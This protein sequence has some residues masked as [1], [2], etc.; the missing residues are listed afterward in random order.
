MKKLIAGGAAILLALGVAGASV[1]PAS[2]HYYHHYYGYGPGA[3]LAAGV[4]GFA[5]GAAL[6]GAAADNRD[7]GDD[8]SDH[9]DACLQA[10]HSYDV[11]SDSYL[12][13]DGYRHRCDL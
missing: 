12:G 5:A 11:R 6:A 8:D 10:Y 1:A 7:Y 2:A 9:V 3:G 4:L 13:Y